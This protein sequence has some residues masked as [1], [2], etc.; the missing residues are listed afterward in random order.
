V[1]QVESSGRKRLMMDGKAGKAVRYKIHTLEA[2]GVNS[3]VWVL[4]RAG[5]E[6]QG[7]SPGTE[8]PVYLFLVS[9]P[10]VRK[11]QIKTMPHVEKKDLLEPDCRAA[12]QRSGSSGL[13]EMGSGLYR[14][15]QAMGKG[16][17]LWSL[18][19]CDHQVEQGDM[20]G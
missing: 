20:P 16:E 4:E 3:A 19:I 13:A 7:T 17:S 2:R 1:G 18:I 5:H 15:S 14:R 10:D 12:P 8:C 6:G 9:A 11:C